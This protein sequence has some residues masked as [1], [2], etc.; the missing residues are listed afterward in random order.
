MHQKLPGFFRESA[1]SRCGLGI[2]QWPWNILLYLMVR[3]AQIVIDA[4]KK[5][6]KERESQKGSK[7]PKFRQP[8]N[9]KG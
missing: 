6:K 4:W 8:K 2:I 5:K 9:F 7:S 1:D 3:V